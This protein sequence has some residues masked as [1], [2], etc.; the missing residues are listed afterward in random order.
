[1]IELQSTTIQF[2][3]KVL[4]KNK[5]SSINVTTLDVKSVLVPV[6]FSFIL[7]SSKG[8]QQLNSNPRLLLNT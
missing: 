7:A 4:Y 8:A 5:T 3:A 1:M 6:V 2:I